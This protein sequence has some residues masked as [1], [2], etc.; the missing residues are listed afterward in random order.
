MGLI[1]KGFSVHGESFYILSEKSRFFLTP[2]LIEGITALL[3]CFLMEREKLWLTLFFQQWR[4][5]NWPKF[6]FN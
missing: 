1:K 5:E 2:S 6:F 4:E 3:I